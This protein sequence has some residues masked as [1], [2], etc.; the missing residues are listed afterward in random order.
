MA[1]AEAEEPIEKL[2]HETARAGFS[3]TRDQLHR[4]QRE[5]LLP[6]PRQRGRGRGHG[7]E[8]LYPPGTARQL[9]ALC[10]LLQKKRSL[11]SACWDLWWRSYPVSEE[12]V[13]GL[14]HRQ[15]AYVEAIGNAF[16]AQL[17]PEPRDEARDLVKALEESGRARLSHPVVSRMRRR[18]GKN[19]F[20][21]FVNFL[22]G[23][24]A[25][26]RPELVDDDA[27]IVAKGLGL[28]DPNE[29][30][31]LLANV[32]GALSP[33]KL[34]EALEGASTEDLAEAKDEVRAALELVDAAMSLTAFA[35]GDDWER[36]V[37]DSLKEPTPDDGTHMVLMWLS[38]RR[39][40]Q[41]RKVYE[42]FIAACRKAAQGMLPLEEAWKKLD[43]QR[44]RVAFS[45][46]RQIRSMR[47]HF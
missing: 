6:R 7:T 3:V 42:N 4:W 47:S 38:M 36:L 15:V 14:F 43:Q 28:E 30:G 12:R 23:T 17:D 21:T 9:V 20:P 25:G 27:E 18:I 26:K 24:A 35:K 40:P 22:A 8:V 31:D 5:G 11:D 29:V 1:H 16:D 45:P 34:R 33:R 44:T 10:E 41:V 13:R 19:R 46:T 37:V 2:L 39:S 32:S